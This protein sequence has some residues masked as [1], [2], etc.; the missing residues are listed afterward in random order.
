MTSIKKNFQ[1][2]NELL[3]EYR[4]YALLLFLLMFLVTVF[5]GFG[6]ALI[7]P[8]LTNVMGKKSYGSVFE[9]MNFLL[10][11]FPEKYG[12]LVLLV[13]ISAIILIKIILLIIYRAMCVYF[14]WRLRER[15]ALKLFKNYLFE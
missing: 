1:K 4:R 13:I 3:G 6:V 10:E 9:P 7:F 15:W 5:E 14:V 2:I 11:K 8:L 12:I